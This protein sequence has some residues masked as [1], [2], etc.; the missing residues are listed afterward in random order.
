MFK[1]KCLEEVSKI[2]SI[3]VSR[4]RVH[5]M[6]ELLCNNVWLIWDESLNIEMYI[7]ERLSRLISSVSLRNTCPDNW[8]G[9]KNVSQLVFDD[10]KTDSLIKIS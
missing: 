4:H 9:K 3:F 10:T 6:S 5:K 8:Q 1:K 7:F 2:A